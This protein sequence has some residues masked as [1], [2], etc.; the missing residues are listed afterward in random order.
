M[1]EQDAVGS[2]AIRQIAAIQ[3]VRGGDRVGL[4]GLR[5]RQRLP[6]SRGRGVEGNGL[7]RVAREVTVFEL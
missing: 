5:F 7:S 4:I 6:T 2:A 3:E 1:D